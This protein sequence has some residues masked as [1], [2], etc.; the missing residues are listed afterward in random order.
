MFQVQESFQ[1]CCSSFF[2]LAYRQ[3]RVRSQMAL[4]PDWSFGQFRHPKV[5]LWPTVNCNCL[6]KSLYLSAS[7]IFQGAAEHHWALSLLL[8]SSQKKKKRKKRKRQVAQR[9]RRQAQTESTHKHKQLIKHIHAHKSRATH[10]PKYIKTYFIKE[11]P[12]SDMH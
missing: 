4:K 7:V 1:I 3:Q 5:R 12:I 2:K 8:R 11:R 10:N 6:A 9:L